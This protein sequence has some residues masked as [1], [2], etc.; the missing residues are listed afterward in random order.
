MVDSVEK[1]LDQ[2]GKYNGWSNY[3]TWRVALD[4]FDGVSL[5]GNNGWFAPERVEEIVQE[6]RDDQ[7]AFCRAH[8][9]TKR[10]SECW[11]YGIVKRELADYL[12]D[13]VKTAVGD[14]INPNFVEGLKDDPFVATI[15][16]WLMAW[17]EDVSFLEI[18]DHMIDGDDHFAGL[19]DFGEVK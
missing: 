12:K 2:E 16:G 9:K 15:E 14:R 13:G 19:F 10:D 4:F 1:H 6:E 7:E 3:A 8:F 11:L 5:S 17:L 18:V